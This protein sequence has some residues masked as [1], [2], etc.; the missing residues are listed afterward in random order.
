MKTATIRHRIDDIICREVLSFHEKN[1]A[2]VRLYESE[3]AKTD[4]L[5]DAGYR[6]KKI[7]LLQ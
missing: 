7:N 6:V 4:K 2:L 1:N 5:A 3:K